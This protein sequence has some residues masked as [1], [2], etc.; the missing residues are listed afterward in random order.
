MYSTMYGD[1]FYREGQEAVTKPTS[2]CVSCLLGHLY[3]RLGKWVY[4]YYLPVSYVQLEITA[5]VPLDGIPRERAL[6][7]GSSI[8]I[9]D[10]S[11]LEY[12]CALPSDK[13]VRDAPKIDDS[14]DFV[15]VDPTAKRGEPVV[16]SL[17]YA[18]MSV[19][20]YRK[21]VYIN[22]VGVREDWMRKGDVGVGVQIHKGWP[23][24]DGAY[25]VVGKSEKSAKDFYE[26]VGF[27]YKG[28]SGPHDGYV[29]YFDSPSANLPKDLPSIYI[30]LPLT[31][32]SFVEQF[33]Y[34]LIIPDS[35]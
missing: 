18:L 31:T 23:D 15:A 22:D 9:E 16:G 11:R 20:G 2:P 32:N 17:E 7:P 33:F 24:V 5:M 26:K 10:A 12:R 21:W 25:L 3:T 6:Y 30:S 19:P 34:D 8:T 35:E 13:L 1:S 4:Y 14:A 28:K 29:F 27:N